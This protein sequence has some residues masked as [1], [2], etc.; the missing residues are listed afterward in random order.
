M[1]F[2]LTVVPPE[3]QGIGILGGMAPESTVEYYRTIIE[4]S[5]DRGWEKRYPQTYVNSL[6]FEAFYDPISN[7]EDARVLEVLSGGVEDLA[8]AGA[9]FALFASNTPHRYFED[10]AAEASIPMLSIVDATGDAAV[11]RGFERVGL[12]GT[13]FTMEGEFYPSGFAERDL[14]IATPTASEREWVHEKIFSELTSGQFT[15]ETKAG[16]IEAVEGMQARDDIDAV[17]L[18]CTELPLIIDESDVDVPILNTT[19]L[20]A[21]AAFDRATATAESVRAD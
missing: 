17:A 4:A 12:L 11:D 13:L 14:E 20:H 5:H 2:G 19:E 18:A 16:L 21:R 7:G 8:R 1:I 10:V 9:D 3:M 6:N 15:D